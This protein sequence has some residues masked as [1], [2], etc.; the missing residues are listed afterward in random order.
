MFFDFA[1]VFAT[2]TAN[3]PSTLFS[4]LTLFAQILIISFHP[5]VLRNFSVLF[6]P[7]GVFFFRTLSFW[8]AQAWPL[9]NQLSLPEFLMHLHALQVAILKQQ[10]HN[11][12]KYVEKDH[13]TRW[14]ITL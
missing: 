8:T 2:L 13:L 1:C 12:H 14:G 10:C 4:P 5:I 7:S 3:F 9:Q 11:V 6:F